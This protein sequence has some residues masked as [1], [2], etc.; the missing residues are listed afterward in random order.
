M[1]ITQVDIEHPQLIQFIYE[2]ADVFII[3][4][5]LVCPK[6]I[7]NVVSLFWPNII[8]FRPE[9]PYFFV[10]TM[11]DLRDEVEHN[12]EEYESK[13]VISKAKGEKYIKKLEPNIILNVYRRNKSMLKKFL[14]VQ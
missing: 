10:G 7:E 3:F 5:S 2:E 13:E 11:S 1:L 9:I 12:K 6:S 8:K 14:N 4:F